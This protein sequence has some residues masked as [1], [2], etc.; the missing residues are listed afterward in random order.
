MKKRFL[1]IAILS[2][3]VLVGVNNS[4]AQSAGSAIKKYIAK[5]AKE[6][7][8]VEY[9]KVRKIIYGDVNGDKKKDAIVQFTLEG[10]DGG[11]NWG[12]RLAVFLN[13]GKSYKFIG[14]EIVGGKFFTYTS[15]LK[16][17]TD[18][19][20]NLTTETCSEPPQG[21]CEKPK[22]G[23]AVFVVRSGKLKQL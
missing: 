9:K 6:E 8:A 16:S 7:N 15:D 4:L 21:L 17:V 2:F 22:R 23:K 13:T 3:T 12:Q 20:I 19:K 10:F 14:E 5:Q 11:N 18:N 1:F